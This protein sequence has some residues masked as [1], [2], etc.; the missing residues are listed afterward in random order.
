M[1]CLLHRAT[2]TRSTGTV[3]TFAKARLTSAAIWQISV[4]SRFMS[5]NHFLYLPIVTYPVN[6]PCT[7][8]VIRIA[9]EI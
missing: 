5:V 8:T 3:H 2:I 7:Q 6:N 9:T 4:S 1:I